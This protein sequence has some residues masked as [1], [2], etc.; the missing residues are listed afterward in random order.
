MTRRA[1]FTIF[2]VIGAVVPYSAVAVFL[3]RSGFDLV[4]L[5]HEAFGSPGATFFALDVIVSAC[6]VIYGSATD[7][8]LT[9][10][11]WA[12]IVASVLIG[13]SCGLPMWQALRT[14][15]VD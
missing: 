6:A 13:P 11:R 14:P 8:R 12:P 5:L 15:D 4:R 9:N 2:A 3:S 7:P 1:V 10:W